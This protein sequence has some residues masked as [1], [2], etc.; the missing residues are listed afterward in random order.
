MKLT[1]VSSNVGKQQ[2]WYSSTSKEP[3]F[4]IYVTMLSLEGYFKTYF[5]FLMFSTVLLV[6]RSTFKAPLP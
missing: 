6:L 2:F 3:V 1:T 5:I 4:T